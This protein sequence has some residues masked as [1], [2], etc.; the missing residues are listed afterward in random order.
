[1]DLFGLTRTQSI[2]GKKFCLIIVDDY[3]RFTWVYFSANKSEAFSHLSKFAKKVQN[4]KG[5]AISS[6]QIDHG[7]EFKNQN[8]VVERK[9]RSLSEN[10]KN[11]LN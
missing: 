1:M 5:Y 2:G 9:N 4:E 11:P 3:S 6:I 10:G 7:G 8:G